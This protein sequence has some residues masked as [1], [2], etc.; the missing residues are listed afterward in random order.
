MCAFFCS[1]LFYFFPSRSVGPAARTHARTPL[2]RVVRSELE[3]LTPRLSAKALALMALP[4]N[5][6]PS[7]RELA[8]LADEFC[9]LAGDTAVDSSWY[10]RRA[11]LAAVYASAELFM[12]QDA[13][14]G[15]VQTEAFLERRLRDVDTV[16]MGVAAVGQW[17]GFTGMG[18]VN[19]LRSK[20]VRI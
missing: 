13:S 3:A 10:T 7:V 5:V 8:L 20:G 4:R 6:P 2:P 17:I 9:F 14:R 1:L 15:F 11:A 18:V 12:T 19:A 16:G